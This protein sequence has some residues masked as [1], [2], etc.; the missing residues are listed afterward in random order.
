MERGKERDSGMEAGT[1]GKKR[2]DRGWAGERAAYASRQ[3]RRARA[4]PEGE[5]PRKGALRGL[6]MGRETGSADF[7]PP[8]ELVSPAAGGR[9]QREKAGSQKAGLDKKEKQSKI[10]IDI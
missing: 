8:F 9:R 6:K 4:A 2:A 10:S 5:Q 7:R 1:G 3:G